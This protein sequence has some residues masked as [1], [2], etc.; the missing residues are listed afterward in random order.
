MAARLPFALLCV[1]GLACQSSA[2]AP[3]Q[4]PPAFGVG[5]ANVAG[6]YTVARG[7]A[8]SSLL[9]GAQ[10]AQA[11]GAPTLKLF[12]TPEYRQKY[13]LVWPE[14]ITSLAG[15]ARSAPMQALLALPF[16]TV[17]LT[18]YSF[19]MGT[20]DPWRAGEVPELVE[21]DALELEGL[22]DALA[23]CPPAGPR[24][25]ILQTWEGDW[26]LTDADLSAPRDEARTARMANWLQRRHQA[27]AAAR[28]RVSAPG[29][30]F[31]DAVEVNRVL[32]AGAGA[33]RVITDVLPLITPDAVSYSAWEALDVGAL[34][35]AERS[36]AVEARLTEALHRLRGVLSAQTGLYLG[37]VGFA[38]QEL[39]ATG[40]LL[41]AALDT[42]TREGALGAIYWQLFDNECP[43]GSCRGFWIVRPDGTLSQAG[44][45]LA[46]RWALPR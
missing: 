23:A 37:E 28:A 1:L 13:P 3:P 22:I 7:G 15:L 5:A 16:Q 39:D 8:T 43:A 44:Q 24:T 46:R 12:F 10:W 36:A 26:A 31:A 30:R 32:D 6:A 42:A 45:E 18:T 9:A 41:A 20:G 35:E 40:A 34:P 19:A 11:L 29:L 27:V 25:Y 33:M 4:A 2:P 17:V 14:G 21:A 38:E